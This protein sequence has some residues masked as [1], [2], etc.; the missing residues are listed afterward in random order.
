MGG[1]SMWMQGSNSDL[2]TRENK[3]QVWPNSTGL[4][5]SPDN[6]SNTIYNTI[7][8]PIN[9][10]SFGISNLL[11]QEK[12]QY[13]TAPVRQISYSSIAK[14]DPLQP[15][16]QTNNVPKKPLISKPSFNTIDTTKKQTHSWKRN[17][18]RRRVT[19]MMRPSK[20][21]SIVSPPFCLLTSSPQKLRLLSAP[22]KTQSLKFYLKLKSTPI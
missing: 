7:N 3:S 18:R 9:Q 5:I 8:S 14:K 17:S 6:V 13:K 16:K 4:S 19:T 20:W 2:F 12:P 1:Q 10:I 21:Q 11:T 15:V 22:R